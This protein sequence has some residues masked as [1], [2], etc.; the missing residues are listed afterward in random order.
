[1]RA[2]TP[3]MIIWKVDIALGNLSKILYHNYI[4]MNPNTINK[5]HGVVN[6]Y[7]RCNEERDEELNNRISKRNIP[8]TSLQP[9]YSIRPVNTKYGYMP[10]LDQ[11][12]EPKTPLNTYTPY[13]TTQT[14]NPGNAQAPWNGFS[15]NVNTES[16]LRNQF[17]ALQ[18]CEQSEFVPSSD[19]D[20]YKTKVDFKPMEQTHPLLFNK[21]EFAPFN[22]NTL[23]IGNNLFNNHTRYDIKNSDSC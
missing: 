10:I 20:L 14:F 9:Q 4:L 3:H 19:S 6:G 5:M 12:K 11:Y 8:S 1:M 22:P 18:K 23:N 16:S 2:K 21:P 7:F 15:N 13:S 17:F